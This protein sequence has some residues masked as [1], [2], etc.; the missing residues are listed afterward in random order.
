M[1][2]CYPIFAIIGGIHVILFYY[3]VIQ[4]KMHDYHESA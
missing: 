2:A 3:F 4:S 1:N